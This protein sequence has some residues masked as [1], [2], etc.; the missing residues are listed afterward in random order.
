MQ[1]KLKQSCESI[2]LLVKGTLGVKMLTS[3][4][5]YTNLF[6]GMDIGSCF[7]FVGQHAL[8]LQRVEGH[9]AASWT[10]AW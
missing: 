4:F 8:C 9:C 3:T 10:V 7:L 5:R 6:D 1:L 2:A